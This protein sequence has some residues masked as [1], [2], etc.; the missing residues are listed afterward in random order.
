MRGLLEANYEYRIVNVVKEVLKR[1]RMREDLFGSGDELW[2]FLD[3][4]RSVFADVLLE[5]I[6]TWMGFDDLLKQ[7]QDA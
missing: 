7:V 3:V 6:N 1:E 4:H 5:D 2:S